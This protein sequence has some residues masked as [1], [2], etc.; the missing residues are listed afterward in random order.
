LV[1]IGK[2]KTDTFGEREGTGRKIEKL[3]EIA[4]TLDSKIQTHVAIADTRF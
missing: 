1:G 2:E 3:P 4:E